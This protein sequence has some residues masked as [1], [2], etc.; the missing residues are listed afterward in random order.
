MAKKKRMPNIEGLV[1]SGVTT[2]APTPWLES[3]HP[4]G[5]VVIFDV[6]CK[7]CG[8]CVEFCPTGALENGPDGI[9]FLANPDKCTL[10]GLCWLRCPDIAIIKGPELPQ[11]KPTEEEAEKTRKMLCDAGDETTVCT[12]PPE[13]EAVKEAKPEEKKEEVK[14]NAKK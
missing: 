5:K 3:V 6:W 9:P 2:A 7:K 13:G 14:Q 12:L 10:C 4:E 1:L 11:N 8:I